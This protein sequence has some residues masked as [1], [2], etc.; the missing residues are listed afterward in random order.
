[1]SDGV[2]SKIRIMLIDDNPTFLRVATDFLRRYDDLSVVGA[3][4]GGE[5]ALA[6]LLDVEPHVV[7]L[8][9]A[10][11]GLSGLETIPRLRALMPHLG[12]V[13]LTMLDDD[14]YRRAVL[15]AG[16]DDYVR[17]ASMYTDLLPAIRQAVS[18]VFSI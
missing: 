12:I 5:E 18:T 15:A 17:K 1:M 10:M 14:T 16:A 8:D 6:Q 11:P 13:I 2:W 4:G 9:L 3:V 7:L